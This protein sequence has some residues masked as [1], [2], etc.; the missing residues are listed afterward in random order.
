[1]EAAPD[2]DSENAPLHFKREHALQHP[3]AVLLSRGKNQLVRMG[4][5]HPLSRCFPELCTALP[6]PDDHLLTMPLH[7]V[8][9]ICAS[10][11]AKPLHADPDW[12]LGKKALLP[13][14]LQKNLTFAFTVGGVL[15]R[16]RSLSE[17]RQETEEKL[18]PLAD[19][20]KVDDSS[21]FDLED[22]FG[23]RWSRDLVDWPIM[24]VGAGSKLMHAYGEL[25]GYTGPVWRNED[26]SDRLHPAIIIGFLYDT[27]LEAATQAEPSIDRMPWVVRIGKLSEVFERSRIPVELQRTLSSQADLY[28]D[29]SARVV[30]WEGKSP[31]STAKLVAMRMPEVLKQ[32]KFVL[33]KDF[34]GIDVTGVQMHSELQRLTGVAAYRAAGKAATRQVS[35][36]HSVVQLEQL[37]IFLRRLKAIWSTV[38]C[39]A[40]SLHD[41]VTALLEE[42]ELSFRAEAVGHVSSASAVEAQK[43]AAAPLVGP[44]AFAHDM[45][46]LLMVELNGHAFRKLEEQLLACRDGLQI[47]SL[48]PSEEQVRLAVGLPSF[49]FPLK[50]VMGSNCILLK[51]FVLGSRLRPLAARP[52]FA[53]LDTLREDWEGFASLRLIWNESTLIT[54]EM[55]SFKAAHKLL[56][57]LRAGEL[58]RMDIFRDVYDLHMSHVKNRKTPEGLNRSRI[59]SHDRSRTKYQLYMDRA[60]STIGFTSVETN[61]G[62]T[63]SHSSILDALNDFL[64]EGEALEGSNAAMLRR[65]AMDILDSAETAAQ[66]R[67]K[68]FLLSTSPSYAFPAPF[69]SKDALA[70]HLLRQRQKQM[71]ALVALR[72]FNPDL[73]DGGGDGARRV[74]E[75]PGNTQPQKFHR[76]DS[77]ALS[78][79]VRLS[80]QSHDH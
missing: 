2:I 13:S 36:L 72:G 22:S 76:P 57:Q 68:A 60:L 28:D 15:P 49:Y 19:L 25:I 79:S 5:V 51:K 45:H 64:E 7:T 62:V 32:S 63:D 3:V 55:L 20:L 23:R 14:F 69:M 42:E 59:M 27:L 65:H 40:M 4:K 47:P 33:I 48:T 37:V 43:G 9:E 46:D 56:S 35:P 73:F 39:L 17:W 78:S 8:T 29:I 50:L 67:I 30:L 34:C 16:P 12:T 18:S 53:Y 11:C 21:F 6:A 58:D 70:K 24:R 10:V 38:T 66:A 1:M 61:G 75:P 31:E 74:A 44:A 41:R 71:T 54:T 77:L 80:T 52:V 26:R